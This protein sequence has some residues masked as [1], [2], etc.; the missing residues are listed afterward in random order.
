MARYAPGLVPTTG[1]IDQLERWLRTEHEEVRNSTD[2]I[3]SIAQWLT[4]NLVAAGYGSI[5]LD[6]ITPLA[7]INAT[8]QQVPMDT[9]LVVPKA[10]S[11]DLTNEALI[12][13]S[14][15]IW[16]INAKIALEFLEA[17]GSRRM[18]LRLFNL[19]TGIAPTTVFTYGIGRNTDAVNLNLSVM[20]TIT[21]GQVGD[22]YQ[23]QIR[24]AA[25]TFT[26]V[27]NTGNTWDVNH[28][29]EYKGDILNQGRIGVASKWP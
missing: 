14:E 15:G 17:Q 28:V 20:T 24:S 7:G 26:T 12:F 5:G 19:T 3:Y 4:E 18:E 27:V 9:I 23:L 1:D 8:W 6:A 22:S 2:D 16:R 11:Y 21:D 29:S 25:D 10:V 13:G